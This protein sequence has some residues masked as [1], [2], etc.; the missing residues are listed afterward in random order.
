MEPSKG[1]EPFTS[2]IPRERTASR[3][4]KACYPLGAFYPK[5]SICW[6][7]TQTLPLAVPDN[8][9]YSRAC[10]VNHEG[11]EPS[12]K[13]LRVPYST[14]ELMVL[15]L[16]LPCSDLVAIRAHEVALCDLCEDAILRRRNR[17]K[18][19]ASDHR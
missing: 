10:L 9:G 19:I 5:E 7:Q 1:L 4:T 3:A 14:I 2:P 17:H 16:L 12:T 18:V 8:Q 13:G 11:L 15:V 6:N